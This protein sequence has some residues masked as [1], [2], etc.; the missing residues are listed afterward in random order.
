MKKMIFCFDGTCND[1]SDA[2]DFFS[3]S[4]ISNVLKLHA[5]FGGSLNPLNVANPATKGQHSFYY[6]GVGTRGNWLQQKINSLIAPPYAD[7]SDILDEAKNDLKKYREGDEIYVFG[8][9]RGAAIARIF[10]AKHL[11]NRKVKFL[12][13]FDTVAAIR[14]SL[15]L[16]KGTFP[17]S[18][19]LFENGT[20]GRRIEKAVHLVAIDEKRLAFQPTLFNKDAKRVTE[21]WFAG[22]HSDIGG[23]YWFDG[24]SDI[25]LQVMCDYASAAGLKTLSVNKIKYATLKSPNKSGKTKPDQAIFK[26][27]IAILPMANGVL[28]E[29]LRAGIAAKTLASREVRVSVDDKPSKEIPILHHSVVERFHKTPEYRPY[30]LRNR[31]FR[32]MS[33]DG[34]LSKT[35]T[36]I[37]GLRAYKLPND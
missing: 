11:G 17:S 28:H 22:V 3:D 14:G 7:M 9:S 21:I 36:G 4:S 27:D 25:T 24:L 34:K 29:Q 30:S 16:N 26:D 23:G 37:E 10:A 35:M 6:S 31:R 20:L 8:F 1:P 19:I 13:V 15:D 33:A 12:G 18:G 32:V 2:G 5:L